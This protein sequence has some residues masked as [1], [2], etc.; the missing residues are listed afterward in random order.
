MRYDRNWYDEAMACLMEADRG[1]KPI[2]NF[3]C[4]IQKSDKIIKKSH[5][6]SSEYK[7]AIS[8]KAE[9][10]G[11][12]AEYG[13]SP[14][15]TLEK[16]I[17]VCDEALNVLKPPERQLYLKI[18]LI[19]TN[20][21]VRLSEH[22]HTAVENL[23]DAIKIC[24][25]I[26]HTGYVE[27]PEYYLAFGTKGNAHLFL[28]RLSIKP[29]E[30]LDSAILAY[31]QAL[32]GLK[33]LKLAPYGFVQIFMNRA[34]AYSI[35]SSYNPSECRYYLEQA[36]KDYDAVI[37][38]LSRHGHSQSQSYN[39]TLVNKACILLRLAEHEPTQFAKISV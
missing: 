2:E 35:M 22:S 33:L 24:N 19:K 23:K 20:A 39:R 8:L 16:A 34:V 25:K 1:V 28:A 31:T 37:N 12:L 13:Y 21:L 18:L 29:K 4:V 17:K 14:K 10:L 7:I 30:N 9:A 15:E 36:F 11:W 5:P 38:I 3:L 27:F 26:I 32:V 6:N